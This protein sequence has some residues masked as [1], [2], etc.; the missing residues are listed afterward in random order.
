MNESGGS[1]F[2]RALAR[3]GQ[4]PASDRPPATDT[5]GP[6]SSPG[7]RD[8]PAARNEG[9]AAAKVDEVPELKLDAEVPDLPRPSFPFP[10]E[11]SPS[12]RPVRDVLVGAAM[13]SARQIPI[14]AV[15]VASG[16]GVFFVESFLYLGIQADEGELRIAVLALWGFATAFCAA[17]TLAAA[18][19]MLGWDDLPRQIFDIGKRGASA[20]EALGLLEA[21]RQ[22]V[23][24]DVASFS[25]QLS[26][27]LILAGMM[28]SALWISQQVDLFEQAGSGI[29][30]ANTKVIAELIPKMLQLAPRAFVTT[31]GAVAAALLLSFQGLLQSGWVRLSAVSHNDV[32]AAW[33]EGDKRRAHD[34]AANFTR[35]LEET[36]LRATNVREMQQAQERIAKALGGMS[37]LVNRVDGTFQHMTAMAERL[38]AAGGAVAEMS[39]HLGA[40]EEA[41]RNALDTLTQISPQIGEVVS[42]T[43]E[44]VA[45]VLEQKVAVVF[46]RMANQCVDIISKVEDDARR[47][48]REAARVGVG[49]ALAIPDGDLMKLRDESD[50]A[51]DNTRKMAAELAEIHRFW[52]AHGEGLAKGMGDLGD[53]LKETSDYS[54]PAAEAA[55]AARLGLENTV[56]G[57]ERSTGELRLVLQQLRRDAEIMGQV[58][59][60][61]LGGSGVRGR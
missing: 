57:L 35:R 28:C 51:I 58:R 11:Q 54:A 16:A 13:N 21:R 20:S 15:G 29:A 33:S 6:T 59:E 26:N 23:D 44:R 45:T 53:A 56:K 34:D 43:S 40:T 22:R 12:H 7:E 36:V 18:W 47:G 49:A 8:A 24:S 46:E 9:V 14:L 61:V 31:A 3:S 1:F 17:V 38:D 5:L 4:A 2:D 32:L 60:A 27:L 25:S 37:D 50:A 52:E 55:R 41:V 39:S 42:Q 30:T 10:V 48:V 19:A